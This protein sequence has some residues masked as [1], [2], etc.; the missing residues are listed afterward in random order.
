MKQSIRSLS[1]NLLFALVLVSLAEHRPTR[2]RI[3]QLLT[4]GAEFFGRI[5]SGK[6]DA[7]RIATRAGQLVHL[8]LEQR[9]V[10]A[11]LSILDPAGV[12]QVG[13]DSPNRSWGPE[14]I[15]WI[16]PRDGVWIVEIRPW[17]RMANGNY[18]LRLVSI[19]PPRP[20]DRLRISARERIEKAERLRSDGDL[21]SASAELIVARDLWRASVEP[22][23][24]TL[25][26][27][28]LGEIAATLGNRLREIA[29]YSAAIGQYRKL[30]E[31]RQEVYA[32]LLLGE[33][34]RRE[35]DLESAWSAHEAA[36]KLAGKH[37][38]IPEGGAALNNQAL[39]LEDRGQIRQAIEK[40]AL[41]L[42]A[43]RQAGDIQRIS[44]ALNNLG[45]CSSRMGLLDQAEKYLLESLSLRQILG[46]PTPEA[47]TL[48][49]LGTLYHLKGREESRQDLLYL[50]RSTLE[51]A[52]NR[53]RVSGD[54]VGEAGTLDRLGAV[55]RDL[56]EWQRSYV[57]RR[58]AMAILARRP[59]S[60]DQAQSLLNLAESWFDRGD[61]S[62]ARGLTL[63]A[64]QIFRSL[65][66]RSPSGEA[67]AHFLLGRCAASQDDFDIANPEFDRSLGMIEEAR[68]NLGD[69]A[70][71]LHF[72]ALRQ[73]YFEGTVDALMNLAAAR[74]GKAPVE[75]ALLVAERSHARALIDA[76]AERDGTSR[77]REEISAL[78]ISHLREELLDEETAL[79]EF[80]LGNRRSYAWLLTRTELWAWV[81][82]GR[83]VLEPLVRQVHR[84]LSS[85]HSLPEATVKLSG[86][87]LNPS[88]DRPEIKRL[89]IV[90]DGLLAYVP[91]AALP[92]GP[93]KEALIKR[94][95][96]ARLPSASTVLMQRRRKSVPSDSISLPAVV[97]ADPVFS[98]LD[99]R[100]RSG[101]RVAVSAAP[102]DATDLTRA[103]AALGMTDLLRLPETRR[104][105]DHIK[106]MLPGSLIALDFS[107]SSTL[108]LSGTAGQTRILHLATHSLV[109]PVNPA[110]SGI[111]LSLV[112]QEGSPQAGFLQAPQIASLELDADLV[113]LSACK[114]AI[115]PE[116]RGEGLLGLSRAFMRAGARRVMASLWKVPDRSTADLMTRFYQ[117]Y[118]QEGLAPAS[119]LRHAQLALL[120]EPRTSAARAWAGFEIQGDWR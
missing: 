34:L 21:H 100:V 12:V 54:E 55:F 27:I 41:A 102:Q 39:I 57:C 29:A 52:L 74:S 66:V 118:V 14:E 82:P 22:V 63:R 53:R 32:L 86:L 101:K 58:R 6:S 98:P 43:F 87:L 25:I 113:V 79:L 1:R 71:T 49:E 117:G 36:A 95:E 20:A 70:L 114:T 18:A 7:F 108:L 11:V 16:A 62:Q 13:V 76:I 75:S 40:Y 103:V 10:D 28:R 31:R 17:G 116:V 77:N 56:G 107:A 15:W 60:R 4:P 83:Q 24:S 109:D 120:A 93:N 106:T 46:D 81:L 23:Q 88:L 112:D 96:I 5:G 8:R 50:A 97:L 48:T 3:A 61:I 37:G 59:A 35:G 90:T 64:L 110:R 68:E 89:A 104:E 94:F 44:T 26:E 45:T 65:A 91:F 42:V 92:W 51:R 105:A 69:E 30:G 111:V 72:F 99:P 47:V 84:D 38:W 33:T 119:A 78:S 73:F 9:G 19:A 67:Q 115:G 80:A 2:W 85:S